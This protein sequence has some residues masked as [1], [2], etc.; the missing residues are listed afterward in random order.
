MSIAITG[1]NSAVGQ[2]I[3]RVARGLTPS[4]D[5]V[6][7][8]RSARSAATLPDLAGARLAEIAYD[9]PASLDAAF[10]GT[11]AVIHLAGTLVERPGSTYQTANVDT[12]RAVVDA[13]ARQGVAKVVLVSAVGSD[14]ASSNRYWRS[15]AEAEDLVRRGAKAWTILRVPLLLG[16]GTEGTAAL[17][18]HIAHPAVRLPGGGRNLQQ[19]LAVDDLARGAL[20]ACD[21]AIASGQLL[22]LVGPV[23]VPDR[24]IIER[25]AKAAGRTVRIGSVPVVLLSAL[26]RIQRLFT[27]PGFSAEVVEVIT[28]DTNVDPAPAAKALGLTL[29]GLDDMIA[30]SVAATGRRGT[31]APRP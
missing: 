5:L 11:A 18:R 1:A 17:Q 4:P 22:E 28:A 8:V 21:P 13:A 31:G 16:A 10:A 30:A 29:T 12:T 26:L 24:E 3:L 14:L 20:A 23:A 2:A 9:R 15:K 19:P 25:A 6:A 27:G 7:C